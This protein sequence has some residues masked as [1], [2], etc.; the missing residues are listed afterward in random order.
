MSQRFKESPKRHVRNA[1]AGKRGKSME[2]YVTQISNNFISHVQPSAAVYIAIFFTFCTFIW[3]SALLGICP[4]TSICTYYANALKIFPEEKKIAG[5]K[6]CA[7]WMLNWVV[8]VHWAFLSFFFFLFFHIFFL[9]FFL[10]ILFWRL[11]WWRRGHMC[12]S[13]SLS[14]QTAPKKNKNK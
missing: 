1:E 8:P 2:I 4:Y 12:A 13:N 14:W 3:I 6:S 5:L 10:R 9:S 11:Q 7:L